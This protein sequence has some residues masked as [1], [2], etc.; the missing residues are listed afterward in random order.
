MLKDDVAHFCLVGQILG[1]PH[2]KC[3]LD[4]GF[5]IEC[6]STSLFILRV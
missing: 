1:Q 3:N 6:N 2:L 5:R 4:I